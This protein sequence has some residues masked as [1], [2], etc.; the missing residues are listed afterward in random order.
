MK[1][2]ITV[3]DELLERVDNY[4]EANYLKRSTVFQWGVAQLVNQREAVQALSSMAMTLRKIA[5]EGKIDE[6]TQRELAD[7][8]RVCQLIGK[9]MTV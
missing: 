6:E 9:S 2:N 4:C 8:E 5:E 7:F 1:I 3:P